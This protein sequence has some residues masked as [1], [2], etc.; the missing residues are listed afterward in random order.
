M[1]SDQFNYCIAARYATCDK[2]V[3]FAQNLRISEMK[4]HHKQAYMVSDNMI[5]KEPVIVHHELFSP[6][7]CQTAPEEL[8]GIFAGIYRSVKETSDDLVKLYGCEGDKYVWSRDVGRG[9]H[10]K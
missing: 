10:F 8:G 6:D 5:P 9:E 7:G 2:G 4:G 1:L 3:V